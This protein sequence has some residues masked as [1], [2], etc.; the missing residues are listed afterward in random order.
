MKLL[1][2]HGW[3]FDASFWNPVIARLPGHACV[4]DD[5]GYFGAPATPAVRGP[6]L[7]VA[8]SFGAMRALA[9]AA[10]ECLG[11]VAINGF[12]RF[13]DP[14]DGS[15][16]APRVLDRM[17]ARFASDPGAVLADFRQRC[18]SVN[19]PLPLAPDALRE[20]L[21]VLRRGDFRANAASARFPILS[22]QGQSDPL[23]AGPM[24][25]QAFAGA[26]FLERDMLPGGG[27]LLALSDPDWCAGHI[28]A[29]AEKLA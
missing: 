5:R 19:P 4:A 6:A 16:I 2:L 14:G 11:L 12:A 27:H 9:G 13:T 29:F 1:F 7:V 24:R 21:D 28:A 10:Q 26:R 18:G 20:D 15:G 22:L 17:M 8:H 25:E 3:G 23:L